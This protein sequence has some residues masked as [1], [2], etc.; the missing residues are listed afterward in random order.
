MR[1]SDNRDDRHNH[2]SSEAGQRHVGPAERA[3]NVG[4]RYTAVHNGYTSR[5]LTLPTATTN[6]Q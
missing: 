2:E 3:T 6:R 4:V 1:R 5:R